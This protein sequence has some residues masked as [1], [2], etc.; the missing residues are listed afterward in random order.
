MKIKF[1]N[2]LREQDL[3]RRRRESSHFRTKTESD[4]VINE[5]LKV[6]IIVLC[7]FFT[8]IALRLIY[9]QIFQQKEYQLKLEAFTSSEQSVSPPRGK[10]IDSQGRTLAESIKSLTI[11]Y[12]PS[13]NVTA[14]DEWSLAKK[15]VNEIGVNKLTITDRQIKDMYI[16]YMATVKKDNLSSLLTKK[17]L[18]QAE[19]GKLTVD[20]VYDLK[21]KA[22]NTNNI[23]E[24]DKKI[25]QVKMKMD[26]SPSNEFKTIETDCTS[27]QIAYISEHSASFSGFVGTFGWKR[28]Y[29]YSDVVSSMI[30]SITNE[31]TG[32][33]S[34]SSEYYRALGYAMNDSVGKTGIEKQYEQ[35][36]SGTKTTYSI[37]YDEN[38]NAYMAEVNQGKSGYNLKLT[39]N[40]EF[41]N[42]VDEIIKTAMESAKGNAYRQYWKNCYFVAVNV[43]TGG[44]I[45]MDAI[46]KDTDGNLYS[47]PTA[48][49]LEADRVGSSVKI[50]TL[51]MGLNEG[52]V[53]EG[54]YINDAPMKFKGTDAMASY[55]NYGLINDVTAI[56]K[57]SN[58][59]MWNIALRLG[60]SKYVENSSLYIKDGTFDLMR[61]YYNMFGLGVKT[62]VDLPNEQ[63][64]SIGGDDEPV[65][66][67][68]MAIGQY[69]TYTSMQLAQYV[70]TIA[71]NGK[72]LQLHLL[73]NASEVNNSN[74]I[75]YQ[76]KPN[77]LSTL[78]GNNKYLKDGQT[79]MRECVTASFCE[80]INDSNVG[81]T[82]AA[83]SGTAENEIYVDGK[84]IDTTNAT[85]IAYGPYEDPELAF[86]C[87]APNSNNGFGGS[88][89]GNIAGTILG[90]CAKEYFTNYR[91]K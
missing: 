62:G 13:K 27:N 79:G 19:S 73:D 8:V 18:A 80:G 53:K 42:K 12:Y 85:M 24:T 34:E 84:M 28:Q 33:P 31:T 58:V 46:K 38:G 10:I 64:G 23:S 25:F 87:F 52:V 39:L 89:Q 30:G 20:D 67:L 71:N 70:T 22:I 68:H 83:K 48:T 81:V 40:A 49:Y 77:I 66:A 5:R 16:S 90:Q 37:E 65:K 45:A 61:S 14:I 56:S 59:Y 15:F 32:L 36:L 2:P 78:L 55:H 4:K 63:V 82:M 47:D 17:Q 44:I 57:S 35:L 1:K 21:L 51:Y 29:H 69:D 74:S 91:G 7:V 41:E 9:V 72:R 60:G 43:K 54:E 76:F 88:L 3:N 75:V 86:V 11:S 26:K 6:A 50:A